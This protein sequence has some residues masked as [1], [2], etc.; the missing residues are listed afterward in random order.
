MSWDVTLYR[1]DKHPIT[2]DTDISGLERKPLGTVAQVRDLISK[3]LP[4]V[5]WESFYTGYYLGD[6]YRLDFF[7]GSFESDEDDVIDHLAISIHGL[8]SDEAIDT[9]LRLATPYGWTIQE[10]MEGQLIL[11]N[12]L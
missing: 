4:E 12:D 1:F 7:V 3:Q 8:Y 6:N 9:L 10:M 2:I 11:A 5:E